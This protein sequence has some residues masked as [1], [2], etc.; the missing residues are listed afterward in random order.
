MS[1]LANH[2]PINLKLLKNQE[3]MKKSNLQEENNILF[4]VI[5]KSLLLLKKLLE[6]EIL[7]DI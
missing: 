3:A 4:L 7:T 5:A 6:V 2:T 1:H